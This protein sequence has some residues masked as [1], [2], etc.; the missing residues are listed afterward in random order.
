M[1]RSLRAVKEVL[2]DLNT[3]EKMAGLKINTSKTKVLIQAQKRRQVEHRINLGDYNMEAGT[4]F[5]YWGIR[6][7]NKNEEL[8]EIQVRIHVANRACF[9][10]FYLIT[11]RDINCRV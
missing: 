9:S 3:E 8:V 7:T 5:T 2:Q 6:L 11:C 10:I 4:G 1:G